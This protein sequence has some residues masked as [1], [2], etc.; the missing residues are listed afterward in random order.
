S[1]DSE[2]GSAAWLPLSGWN[3]KFQEVG[4]GA[5]AGSIQYAALAA[6]IRRGYAA[7]STN[8]G[9]TGEDASFALGHPQKLIDFGYRA[10]HETAVQSK[11]VIAAYYGRPP[12]LSYF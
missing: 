8:A 10:V 9:H 3:G 2:L 12:Q 6:A 11:A 4:N 1:R 5:W 7:S